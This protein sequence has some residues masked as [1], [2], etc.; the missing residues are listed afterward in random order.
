MTPERWQQVDKLL[1][2]ALEREPSQRASFLDEACAG[3]E[4]LRQEV[5]SLLGYEN[6]GQQLLRRPALQVMA[7]KLANDSPPLIGQQVGPYQIQ[8]VLGAGGMGEVYKARDTRLNR[9]VAIKVLPRHLCER[10]DLKHRFVQE[11]K[12]ASALNHP[13]IITVYDILSENGRDSI[14]MEYVAGRRWTG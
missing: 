11:A 2:Q 10:T 1:Q 8:S 14:V 6:Q 13:N 12:A 3:D 7:D 4:E 9:M 5:E